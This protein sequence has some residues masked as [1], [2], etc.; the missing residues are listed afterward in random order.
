MS[1]ANALELGM[2][3][4]INDERAA[5]G[6]DPLRLITTLNA[7]A[8]NHSLWM[9]ETDT[10]SHA[11]ADGSTPSDRMEDA[12]YPFE[13]ASLAL[14]N[15]GWQ[16]ARGAEGFEDDVA[17]VHAGLMSSPGHR[18][19]IL[20]PNAEDIGI[21]IEIGTF[22]GSGGD[23]EA[24][25][26]TQVFGTTDADLSAWVDPLTGV[27]EDDVVE[28]DVVDEDDSMPDD[29]PPDDI[30]DDMTTEDAEDC[31]VD[32]ADD[33]AEDDTGDDV[34]DE[35]PEEDVEDEVVEEDL[36]EDDGEDSDDDDIVMED[37]AEDDDVPV[38]DTDDEDMTDDDMVAEDTADDGNGR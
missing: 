17:Q 11:G 19:N 28:E 1:N 14:E 7:A 12:G 16:S 3:A 35:A 9:L 26:V 27:P 22:S 30:G 10:F 38:E 32:D 33:V 23:F 29:L 5:A 8:E 31:E 18:A 4:L 6:L 37:I 34:I 15:I 21:G 13:G 24:V 25:M 20:N 36:P 2:L